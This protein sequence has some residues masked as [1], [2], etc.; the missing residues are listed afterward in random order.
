MAYNVNATPIT[1]LMY[2]RVIKNDGAP[3]IDPTEVSKKVNYILN[4]DIDEPLELNI[5]DLP[6]VFTALRNRLI[7]TTMFDD[8]TMRR[9]DELGLTTQNIKRSRQ[10]LSTPEIQGGRRTRKYKK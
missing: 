1:R 3:R 10:T 4:L 8:R 2:A 5:Y 7:G 9:I 6:I